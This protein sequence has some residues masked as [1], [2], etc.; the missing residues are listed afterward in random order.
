MTPLR[1]AA[2]AVVCRVLAGCDSAAGE[3][4]GETVRLQLPAGLEPAGSGLPAPEQSAPISVGA[5][6][7][8]CLDQPGTARVLRVSGEEASDN[9]A[10]EGFALRPN[11]SLRGDDQLGEIR[12]ALAV[13]LCD[14]TTAFPARC[15][16]EPMLR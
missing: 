6:A 16:T 13:V 12:G 10:V 9:F 3:P 11:P 1:I 4:D 7:V 8:V 14:A 15:A 5:G 2:A